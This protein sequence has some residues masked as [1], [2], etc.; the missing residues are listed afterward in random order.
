MV[1]GRRAERRWRT[2]AA[3]GGRGA[4]DEADGRRWVRG[5]KIAASL[6]GWV[7]GCNLRP[8]HLAIIGR[9]YALYRSRILARHTLPG[10][11]KCKGQRLASQLG[12]GQVV[13]HGHASQRIA[14]Q[15]SRVGLSSSS[16]PDQQ[17]QRIVD[18]H[19]PTSLSIP[20]PAR[21]SPSSSDPHPIKSLSWSSTHHGPSLIYRHRSTTM[22]NFSFAR[23]R[24]TLRG[25]RSS[26]FLLY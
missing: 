18:K 19:G 26:I 16:S 21:L 8:S 22:K 23:S 15:Q 13:P 14:S 4:D 6:V 7:S 5:K 1:D 17:P 25:T 11:G 9:S 10:A 20:S 3:A 12:R 2:S 24:G